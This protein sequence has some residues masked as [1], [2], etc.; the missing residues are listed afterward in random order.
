MAFRELPTTRKYATWVSRSREVVVLMHWETTRL[1]SQY[2]R[3][4]NNRV[5]RPTTVVGT[6]DVRIRPA[7]SYCALPPRPCVSEIWSSTALPDRGAI[8]FS[9]SGAQSM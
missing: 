6:T 1:D 8:S 7:S 5:S 4:P 9:R 3:D 2:N